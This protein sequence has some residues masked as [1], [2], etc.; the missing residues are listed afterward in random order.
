MI[1]GEAHPQRCSQHSISKEKSLKW[2]QFQSINPIIPFF[3]FLCRSNLNSRGKGG[4]ERKEREHVLCA[5]SLGVDLS[6]GSVAFEVS[7]RPHSHSS[8]FNCNHG[9]LKTSSVMLDLCGADRQRTIITG[10]TILGRRRL[11]SAGG[12]VCGALGGSWASCTE[13]SCYGCFSHW[14]QR[15]A[16]GVCPLT[17]CEHSNSHVFC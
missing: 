13:G 3:F 12:R 2:Q 1:R 16:S 5:S 8:G 11:L 14:E 9:S 7:G 10:I 17:E 6:H 4:R 15:A